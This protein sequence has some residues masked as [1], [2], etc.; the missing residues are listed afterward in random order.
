MREYLVFLSIDDKHDV[1]IAEPDL[2][3]TSAECG[4]QVVAP[5]RSKLLAA[6]H[7]FSKFSIIPSVILQTETPE[8][9][10]GLWY[11][12]QVMVMLKEGA[13]EPSSPA[14]HSTEMA[15]IIE[16][17]VPNHPILFIYSDV[18]LSS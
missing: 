5:V 6:D 9:F 11:D 1:K 18:P 16:Q 13:F 10:S 3:F 4:C 14:C 2:P 8:E 12:G 15:T 17:K 7:D